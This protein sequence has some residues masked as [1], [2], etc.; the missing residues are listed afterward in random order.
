MKRQA[1]TF[2]FHDTLMHCDQ[3]F[4]LEIRALPSAF[5][6]WHAS[7]NDAIAPES[8]KP[9]LEA[10]YRRLRLAIIQHGHELSAARCIAVVF[11]QVGISV[12]DSTIQ[13][14]VDEIMRG[15]LDNASPV[16]GV[17]A[18]LS[19][20]HERGLPIGVVSS[21]VHHDFLLWSLERHGLHRYVSTVVTSAGSGYYK[22]RPEI[23]WTALADLNAQPAR[24][25]HIGDSAR[26][27]VD[28][29]ARA[30]MRTVWLRGAG[31]QPAGVDPDITLVQ[32]EGAAP[33]I[34]DLLETTGS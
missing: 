32:F 12:D 2:D 31:A 30:G 19:A 26:F 24:S 4:Q 7:R 3:W 27:D 22:S 1:V 13:A 28:G 34:L 23:Y 18:L 5:L 29:A 8:I 33:R 17:K 25:V 9:E 11:D 6:D 10:A 20:L 16:E 21:A 15:A 14:G